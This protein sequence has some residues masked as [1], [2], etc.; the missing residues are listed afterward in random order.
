MIIIAMKMTVKTP[1]GCNILHFLN[2]CHMLDIDYP[3]PLIINLII[4]PFSRNDLDPIFSLFA[5][6]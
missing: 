2:T 5:N 6:L 1:D 4:F 3:N